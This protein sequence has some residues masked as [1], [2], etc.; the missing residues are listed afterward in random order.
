MEQPLPSGEKA[1]SEISVQVARK[2]V[3]EQ[4]SDLQTA[5]APCGSINKGEAEI[6]GESFQDSLIVYAGSQSCYLEYNFGRDWNRFKASVGVTDDS[7]SDLQVRFEVFGD[8]KELFNQVL[9]FGQSAPVDV[10]V[11][12]VLRLRLQTTTVTTP[13]SS[14]SRYAVWGNARRIGSP[15]AVQSDSGSSDTTSSSDSRQS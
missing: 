15:E 9:S 11:V 1:T 8:G 2:P 13:K 12:G 3:I 7:P 14:A 4:L 6:N 10:D 5:D